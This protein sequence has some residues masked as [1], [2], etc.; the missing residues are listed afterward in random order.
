MIA[1]ANVMQ[2]ACRCGSKQ[3]WCMS[4]RALPWYL[5]SNV[6]CIMHQA[7]RPVVTC[8]DKDGIYIGFAHIEADRVSVT[9]MVSHILFEIVLEW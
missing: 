9:M 5:V 8:L 1:N 6:H 2:C 4:C 3:S 7:Q